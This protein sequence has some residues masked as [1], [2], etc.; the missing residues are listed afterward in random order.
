MKLKEMGKYCAQKQGRGKN[1]KKSKRHYKQ[2]NTFV[3][4]IIITLI[5]NL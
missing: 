5:I 1:Q 2:T 4:T 3:L